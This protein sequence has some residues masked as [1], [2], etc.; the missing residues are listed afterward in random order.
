MSLLYV[1]SG[2]WPLSFLLFDFL[3]FLYHIFIVSLHDWPPPHY[4]YLLLTSGQYPA[5][6]VNTSRRAWGYPPPPPF[7][8]T[9]KIYFLL[10]LGE[11]FLIHN[12][13][14]LFFPLKSLYK[15]NILT[16]QMKNEYF[17][18]N[19]EKRIKITREMILSE[20]PNEIRDRKSKSQLQ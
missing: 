6:E 20:D 11:H 2:L 16:N 3:S 1:L 18:E 4:F 13:F 17:Q 7:F 8:S 10:I 5:S 19:L 14:P 12:F 15:E 9:P